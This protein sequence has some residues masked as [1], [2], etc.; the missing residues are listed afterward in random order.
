VNI[1][2]QFSLL[3]NY[4]LVC[5]GGGNFSVDEKKK[6][7]KLSRFK[8]VLQKEGLYVLLVRIINFLFKKSKMNIFLPT[9][10]D[11]TKNYLA[12][13]IFLLS[14][15][16]VMYGMYK[17]TYFNETTHWNY[18]DFSSKFLGCYELQIQ[19][20]I[21]E[22]QNKYSL[23][24]IINIGAAEGYHVISLI[25]NNYFERGYAFEI[26]KNGQKILKKNLISNKIE[27]KIKILG[28]GNFTTIKNNINLRDLDKS[29]FLI[30]IEGG[31]FSFF[32]K[33]NIKYFKKS[34]FIIE[35]HNISN[36]K[37]VNQFYNLVNDYFILEIINNSSRNPFKF[38]ILDKFTDDEKFLMMSE[39][40]PES[41]RWLYLKPK[42]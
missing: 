27:N 38:T 6:F 24:Y 23:K 21:Y 7:K 3:D 26:D 36:K 4:K 29:L 42:F 33:K 34:H 28:E 37:L 25:K 35:E 5:F 31:E 32:Q 14:N 9:P 13:K 8:T 40:R 16:K 20:K 18:S 39:G 30:D 22:I 1:F 12:K 11:K 17:N 19:N 2:N 41:M 10:I 15:N